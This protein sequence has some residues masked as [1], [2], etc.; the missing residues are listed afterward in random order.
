MPI[1]PQLHPQA[2]KRKRP[3]Q[4]DGDDSDTSDDSIGPLPPAAS[5]TTTTA[6]A[7][8]EDDSRVKRSRIIGPSLPYA[9]ATNESN[10]TDD[11]ES[12][13]ED[14]FGPSLPPPI[15]SERVPIPKSSEN[16]PLERAEPKTSPKVKRDEW[17]TM[18]PT[19]GDWSQRIDPTRMKSRKFNTGRGS[20]VSAGGTDTWNETPEQKQ[21]RLKREVLGIKGGESSKSTPAAAPPSQHDVDTARRIKEYNSQRGPSLY[22]AHQKGQTIEEDDP[23][24]RAFDR[25][26]DIGGG[27]QLNATKRREMV[28]KSS[29]FN[30]RFSSAKYL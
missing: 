15:G 4:N 23:S 27:L 11:Q 28:K 14:D 13:G 6:E 26:K 18:A 22:E 19:S 16:A 2:E 7:A 21:A 10:S 8:D 17:M 1:G 29:D 25:E 5:A 9:K 30:S 3:N 12:S 24:A 20:N